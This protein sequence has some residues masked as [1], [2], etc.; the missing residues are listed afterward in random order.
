[1]LAL[2]SPG[3]TVWIYRNAVKALPWMTSVREKLLDPAYSDWF[4]PFSGNGNYSVPTCDHTFSPPKCSHLYHDQLQ[5]PGFPH[6]DGDCLPPGC[7]VGAGL[8]VG[9]YIFNPLA[10]N[11]SVGGQTMLEWY[12]EEHL[13]GP[14]SG[15]NPNVSGFYL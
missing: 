14:L 8:P 1:M 12:I 3:T 13:F 4:L 7:D 2:Q 15:G 11:V 5:T 9:E 6:G 10:A